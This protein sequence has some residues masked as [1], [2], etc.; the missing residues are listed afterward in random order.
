MQCKT[1]ELR[2]SGTFVPVLAIK[3]EPGCEEDRYLLGRTGYGTD[4]K[5]QSKYVLMCGLS[6]GE[7]K[8]TCDPY[9]WGE[10]RTRHFAHK[11]IIEHFDSLK[12]GEVIDVEFILGEK[13]NKKKSERLE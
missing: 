2:D 13:P 12:S 11:Y 3:L 8:I 6:G 4:P 1:F 10:N 5:V 7:D 9:D